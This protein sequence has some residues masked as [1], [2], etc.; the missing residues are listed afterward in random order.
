MTN[1]AHLTS[2]AL[3]MLSGNEVVGFLQNLVTCDVEKLTVGQANFG[4]LLSPQGKILFDFFLIKREDGFLLDIDAQSRADLTKRLMFYKLR[5]DVKI[6]SVDQNIIAIWNDNKDLGDSDPRFSGMG[7]RLYGEN[8][9]TNSK[10]AD[11]HQM[12]IAIGMPHSGEDF[13]LGTAF[14]HEVLM[15]QF[16]GVDFTK[17]CYVGQEV[18][19]RMQHRGTTRKRIV[20]VQS[21]QNNSL[22]TSHP[23]ILS[24]ERA[25]GLLGSTSAA[26][27]IALVRL[28][29]MDAAV[30]SGNAVEA[31]GI[32][33][34]F[35]RPQFASYEWPL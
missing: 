25:I 12:R 8:I 35:T 27:G 19:S 18:V 5:A 6:E 11:W 9:T 4:A 17:G 23:E 1:S 3:L 2:R 21:F 30:K 31:E 33:L 15:D 16:G 26:I 14:P 28:D 13:E 29:R 20:C 32:E 24:E 7:H 10:E 34:S 22:P